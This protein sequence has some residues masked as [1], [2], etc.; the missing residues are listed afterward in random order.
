V[1]VQV[2]WSHTF[3]PDLVRP[4]GL[5]FDFGVNDGGF[6]RLL[7][8]K[9]RAVVGFEPDPAWHGRHDLPANVRVMPQAVAAKAGTI[10]F[11]VNHALCSSM[12]FTDSDARAVEVEAV[13]L[14]AALA[15]EPEGRIDLVKM[16]IEGEE[17]EVL[18]QAPPQVF[19]RIAQITVEFHDFLDPGRV[20]D[21]EAVIARLEGL[22]FFA[23]CF[24]FRSYGDTLFVNRNL[25]PLSPWD[26]FWLVARF[27]YL[28]GAGRLVTR[29]IGS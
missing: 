17:I 1:N 2:Y 25:L 12:H 3:L 22:G 4:D 18:M 8:P 29:L 6:S 13:T 21:I 7:A 23:V 26:R 24:S 15:M 27:K 5:V 19:A 20:P 16:D 14:E 28:R 9:C 10:P 11:H